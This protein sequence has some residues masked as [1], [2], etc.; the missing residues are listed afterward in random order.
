MAGFLDQVRSDT[1]KMR[2]AEWNDSLATGNAEID[3]HHQAWFEQVNSFFGRMMA[4]EGLESALAMIS[5][6]ANSMEAHFRDED[7]LMARIGYAGA[8]AHKASHQRFIGDFQRLKR[9]MDGG[10]PDAVKKLFQFCTDWMVRHIQAEDKG[11]AKAAAE[12]RVA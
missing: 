2:L 3:R 12:K 10:A 9:Q 5:T 4:G 7:T 1:S 6:F 11:L 8:S